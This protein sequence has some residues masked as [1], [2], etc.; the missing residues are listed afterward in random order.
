MKRKSMIDRVPCPRC[1]LLR[2]VAIVERDETITVKGRD[3]RFTAHLY[4]CGTCGEEFQVPGQ[5]DENL[6]AAREAYA[7]LYETPSP[8]DLVA[9]R[10][11][12][13]ASQK[14]F[15]LILGFGELT[16]NSYEQ[17]AVPTS[18]NRLLLKLAESPAMFKAMY[19]MNS[20]R[21]GAIQRRRIEAS[22]GFISATSWKGMEA[23]AD[24][25]TPVQKE[26]IEARAGNRNQSV[27]A[28]ISAYVGAASFQDYSRFIESAIWSGGQTSEVTQQSVQMVPSEMQA[29]S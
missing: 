10:N 1:E 20:G 8:K 11:K 19:G 18:T 12:Y 21:I 23:L 3:V 4:R 17:G 5:L 7:Q 22:D 28:L 27:L 15:G 6:A 26:K 16:M 25:L 14:A 2:D 24:A 13:G 29:A 9:L